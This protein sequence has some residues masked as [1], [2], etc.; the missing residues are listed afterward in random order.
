MSAVL[1][2]ERLNIRT[3]LEQKLLIERAAKLSQQTTSQFV[4]QSV[5]DSAR[6]KIKEQEVIMLNELES[7][8]FLD[9]LDNPP[10][11]NLALV[12]AVTLY[13]KKVS[14]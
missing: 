3:T 11:P 8:R 4:L 5:L 2:P 10:E 14:T 1:K 13:K 6:E 12:S 7:K 9:L